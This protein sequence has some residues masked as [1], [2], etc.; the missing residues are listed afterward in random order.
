MRTGRSVYLG[1][2]LLAAPL[3]AGCWAMHPG[4]PRRQAPAIS[5]LA[6]DAWPARDV[7]AIEKLRDQ[8]NGYTVRVST[9]TAPSSGIPQSVSSRTSVTIGV[10]YNQVHGKGL[11]RVLHP[12]SPFPQALWDFR[13]QQHESVGFDPDARFLTSRVLDDVRTQVTLDRYQRL[14]QASQRLEMTSLLKGGTVEEGRTADCA[15]VLHGMPIQFPPPANRTP[16]GV[17]LHLHSIAPNPFEPEVVETFQ[18]HGWAVVTL[19]TA[20]GIRP[21]FTPEQEARYRELESK[22][23]D[24]LVHHLDSITE[25]VKGWQAVPTGPVSFPPSADQRREYQQLTRQLEKLADQVRFHVDSDDQIEPVGRAIAAE[26]DEALAS[27]AYAVEAVLDYLNKE[28]P[29]IAPKA[30]HIPVVIVGMSAGALAAPAA[31]V[32]V[33]D[34]I[35]AVVLV[36]GGADLFR[37]SQESSLTDGGIEVYRGRSR[38]PRS[39]REQIDA[40]YLKATRLDPYHTAPLLAGLPVLQVHAAWDGWVPEETGELLYQRLGRPDRMV[41]QGGHSTLFLFLPRHADEIMD[42]IEHATARN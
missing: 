40:A 30:N 26:T 35:D 41:F 3:L 13:R 2:L 10:P 9:K 42:W 39:T 7:P 4:D 21:P 28:R 14:F 32:R 19:N 34:Q 8:T 33:Q 31:A 12:E 22:R 6:A 18:R 24:L 11:L 37:I 36:G 29:D 25:Q 16:R 17:I 1:V 5:A 27:N 20:T 38:A 23:T 15:L